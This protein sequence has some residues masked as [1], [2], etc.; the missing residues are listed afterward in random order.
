M[1]VVDGLLDV[2]HRI[3]TGYQL[4]ELQAPGLVEVDD[5]RDVGTGPGRA[6]AAAH[7]RLVHVHAGDEKGG[8]GGGRRHAED[9][10]A[11]APP[12]AVDGVA[13]DGR[14]SDTLES[15]VDAVGDDGLDGLD[16]VA[17]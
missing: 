6:V 10:A 8:L 4:V 12:E 11:A 5:H 16:R 3:G 2:L 14:V 15:E 7:D 1:Q 17:L 9:D 13:D